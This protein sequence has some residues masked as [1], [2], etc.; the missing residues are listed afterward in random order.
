MAKGA[1]EGA[2]EAVRARGR[3]V[4]AGTEGWAASQRDRHASQTAGATAAQTAG[5]AAQPA[6]TGS[7]VAAD[8][9]RQEGGRAGIWFREDSHPPGAGVGDSR[10]LFLS[11]G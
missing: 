4:C 6:G 7:I 3:V 9:S 2:G 11:S 1:R 8:R 10:N 5:D